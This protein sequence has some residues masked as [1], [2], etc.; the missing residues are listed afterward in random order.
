ML[1][2]RGEGGVGVWGTGAGVGVGEGGGLVNILT[3]AEIPGLG[4][5]EKRIRVE[6]SYDL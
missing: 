2:S 4:I 1:L 6:N 3:D 5:S